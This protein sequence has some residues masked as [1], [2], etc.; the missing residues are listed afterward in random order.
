MVIPNRKGQDGNNSKWKE[1]KKYRNTF[2]RLFMHET[3]SPYIR[4]STKQFSHWKYYVTERDTINDNVSKVSFVTIK[5]FTLNAR[6]RRK[7]LIK[8]W[9]VHLECKLSLFSITIDEIHFSL[10]SLLNGQHTQSVC[11]SWRCQSFAI[12]NHSS[13]SNDHRRLLLLLL[14]LFSFSLSLSF[15]CSEVTPFSTQVMYCFQ[16][17]VASL[18]LTHTHSYSID[19]FYLCVRYCLLI[20]MNKKVTPIICHCMNVFCFMCGN[21]S[22]FVILYLSCFFFC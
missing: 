5:S 18:S 15:H 21:S 22:W 17:Q 10:F 16:Q 6:Q 19:T 1:R 7:S 11:S 8:R 14:L 4:A 3:P 20:K 9:N 13:I 12:M 2:T